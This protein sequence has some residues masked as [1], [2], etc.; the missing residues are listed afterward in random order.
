MSAS[1]KSGVC[2]PPEWQSLIQKHTRRHL[3]TPI[4]GKTRSVDIDA[5]FRTGDVRTDN[6]KCTEFYQQGIAIDALKERPSLYPHRLEILHGAA[7]SALSMWLETP[8]GNPTIQYHHLS[9]PTLEGLWTPRV[10]RRTDLNPTP[11]AL[12]AAQTLSET[13]FRVNTEVNNLF[14]QVRSQ[15]PLGETENTR[16]SAQESFYPY[17]L[18]AMSLATEGNEFYIAMSIFCWALRM[19]AKS[20]GT[21]HP[22]YGL[23]C[24]AMMEL[25]YTVPIDNQ[26][27]VFFRSWLKRHFAKKASIKDWCSSILSDPKAALL[28]G[29]TG[30]G[31]C[32]PYEYRAAAEYA[33]LERLPM[34]LRMSRFLMELDTAGS[35]PMLIKM[36]LDLVQELSE[37]DVTHE[38]WDHPRTQLLNLIREL[39]LPFLSKLPKAILLK[40]LKAIFSPKTYGAG[41]GPVFDA[42]VGQEGLRK[43]FS[44]LED[45]N[46]MPAALRNAMTHG[47]SSYHLVHPRVKTAAKQ[48]SEAFN[49]CFPHLKE[50]NKSA[51]KEWENTPWDQRFIGGDLL[52]S[53]FRFSDSDDSDVKGHEVPSTGNGKWKVHSTY[54]NPVTKLETP[55]SCQ[56]DWP[57]LTTAGT[58]LLGRRLHRWD[59]IHRCQTVLNYKDMSVHGGNMY[60]IH[61][62]GGAAIGDAPT[63]VRAD[64]QALIDLFPD[65]CKRIGFTA[66]SRI[67]N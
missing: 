2:L 67:C 48:L 6:P 32:D 55:V 22:M 3:L 21:L 33:R 9:P 27:W 50:A 63:Y 61:D 24:R 31:G 38:D 42:L 14:W 17:R 16:F 40:I 39:G 29:A 47:C 30:Q 46:G 41:A 59:A 26:S 23:Q 54:V 18:R 44:S 28:A 45:L 15:I 11:L 1:D 7:E 35:G 51:L 34:R 25:A 57:T 19:Y 12:E 5:A 20:A 10:S 52:M 62:A 66:E 58:A 64:S 37:V 53:P 49:K 13:P 36:I 60:G 43:G 8:K 4:S 56:T 65:T